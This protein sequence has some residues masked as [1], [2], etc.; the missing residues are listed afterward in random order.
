MPLKVFPLIFIPPNPLPDS[1]CFGRNVSIFWSSTE[2][3]FPRKSGPPFFRFFRS[4]YPFPMRRRRDISHN[5]SSRPFLG[6]SRRRK[7]A[8]RKPAKALDPAF[9]SSWNFLFAT[10]LFPRSFIDLVLFSYAAN[11]PRVAEANHFRRRPQLSSVS[12]SALAIFFS[13]SRRHTTFLVRKHTEATPLPTCPPSA[14]P[15]FTMNASRTAR[16]PRL[17]WPIRSFPPRSSPSFPKNPHR[18][19]PSPLPHDGVRAELLF[20][21]PVPP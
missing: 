10:H 20:H 11:I 1:C 3:S 5:F 15:E 14:F 9:F 19:D 17:F 21:S 13:L 6:E 12:Y 2:S 18:I 16:R 7:D 4:T 8:Q